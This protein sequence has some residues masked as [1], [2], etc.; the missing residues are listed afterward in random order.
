MI[1]F[2]Y[3]KIL[4]VNFSSKIFRYFLERSQSAR[5]TLAKAIELCPDPEE[6][7]FIKSLQ[8]SLNALSRYAYFD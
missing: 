4:F 6:V 7:Q 1:S 3:N 8:F 5:V 2:V